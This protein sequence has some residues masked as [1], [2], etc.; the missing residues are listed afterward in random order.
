MVLT[1]LALSLTAWAAVGAAPATAPAEAPASR[2]STAA[3]SA[4]LAAV[5]DIRLDGPVG[6]L[7]ARHG[8]QHPSSGIKEWLSADITLGNL[9][10]PVTL[11]GEKQPKTWNFRAPPKNL[12]ALKAAGFHLLNLANN[13]SM[14]YGPQ[15]FLDTLGALKKQGFLY[16]GGGKDLA[17][18]ESLRVIKTAAMRVGF[19]G[20]TS[21]FPKE[22]WAGRRKPGVAYSDFNR[23][24]AL[25]RAARK[26][27]DLLVVSF[28]GGTELAPEPNEIQKAFGRV[29]VKAG[30]DLV[31]GHH[32][33][34]LQAVELYAGKPILHSI[35]NF[36]FV[37]PTPETRWSVIA[38]AHLTPHGVARIDFVPVDTHWG[39]PVPASGEGRLKVLEALDGLGALSAEPERFRVLDPEVPIR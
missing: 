30:A 32:P 3:V 11:R 21:T 29:A 18:A 20:F 16:I 1:A 22:A 26:R 5:G 17:E 2:A 14:D 13:H 7:I 31:L 35:G 8:P 19:L 25:I 9:E 27:C 28:H 12:A 37:S 4:L 33:H 6:E 38:R 39:R 24:P 36:L 15:G 10:C 23:F 34:V